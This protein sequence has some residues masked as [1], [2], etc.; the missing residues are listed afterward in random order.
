LGWTSTDESGARGGRNFVPAPT[1]SLHHFYRRDLELRGRPL[2]IVEL[3]LAPAPGQATQPIG[4]RA[5]R[6]ES[7]TEQVNHRLV[8]RLSPAALLTLQGVSD[9]GRQIPNRQCFDRQPPCS[10][11]L[12][13]LN[14]KLYSTSPPGPGGTAHAQPGAAISSSG[15][16]ALVLAEHLLPPLRGFEPRFLD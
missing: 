6:A 13:S 8:E 14:A 3:I 4:A 15:G 7:L 2:E 11:L 9:A 10:Q 16:V 1:R 5:L 12:H